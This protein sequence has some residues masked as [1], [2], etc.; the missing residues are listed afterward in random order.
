MRSEHRREAP[1]SLW[2][3]Q[4]AGSLHVT[5][6]KGRTSNPWIR[7]T[8]SSLMFRP[9]RH[10]KC[11]NGGLTLKAKNHK[12]REAKEG[13]QSGTSSKSQIRKPREFYH[14][15]F[16]ALSNHQAVYCQILIL[17]PQQRKI[18]DLVRGYTLSRPVQPHN[19]AAIKS[20]N[21][22]PPH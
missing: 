11:L 1:T 7:K 4:P 22:S 6:L 13:K 8:E 9:R 17:I 3:E 12:G 2:A 15:Q 18:R 16:T 20:T 19:S 5:T 21:T 14:E 10:G